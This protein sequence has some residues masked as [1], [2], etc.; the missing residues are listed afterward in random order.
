VRDEQGPVAQIAATTGTDVPTYT[1]ERPGL[2]AFVLED[3][4]VYHTYSP[5]ARGVDGLRSMYQW[6]DRAPKGRNENLM[7]VLLVV[8]MMDVPAM[9]VVTAAI[10][11]ERVAP[12]GERMA[13]AIGTVIIGAGLLM[14][15][16][17]AGPEQRYPSPLLPLNWSAS[18]AKST[19]K[20]VSEP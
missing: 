13:R 14:L 1:R 12:A 10:T 2:S 3:G 16:K 11:L 5:Y 17:S 7:A 20:L 15:A 18:S 6:L 19:L 9:A 8:G 4:V